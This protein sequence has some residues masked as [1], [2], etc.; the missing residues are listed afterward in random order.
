MKKILLLLLALAMMSCSVYAESPAVRVKELAS[1]FGVRKN[2]LMGF[3]LVVGLK[4]TGDT[5]SAFTDKAFTTLLGNMGMSTSGSEFK[6]RNVAA[7]MVTA[8][9]PAFVKSGQKINV[10]VSSIGDAS[11]LKG[12]TLLQ[13][14]LKGADDQVYIAAQGAVVVTRAKNQKSKEDNVE[15]VGQVLE[16]GIVEKDLNYELVN[17]GQLRLVLQKPDFTTATR[18]ATAL[19]RG[20]YSGAKALDGSTVMIPLS[21]DDKDNIVP[22]ISQLEDFLVIPDAVAKIVIDEKTG[23]IVIG[24]NVRLAPVAVTHGLFE[25]EIAKPGEGNTGSE[26]PET[27]LDNTGSEQTTSENIVPQAKIVQL[28]AGASLSSLVR[29]LNAM[30]ASP[31]DLVSIIQALKAAGALTA[32]IE[33]I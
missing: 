14:P 11:S 20:G 3:G 27:E 23:T 2:Q 8:E 18:L 12:G 5:K 4:G 19:D 24:E 13:T 15:T 30:G 6:S 21:A 16:G 31:K 26:V 1:V 29:V 25:I 32:E 17:K 7:V 9:L 28:E 10:V 22:F 33:V